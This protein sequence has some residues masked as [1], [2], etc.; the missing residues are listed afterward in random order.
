MYLLFSNNLRVNL[1]P[2]W[3]GTIFAHT[4]THTHTQCRGSYDYYILHSLHFILQESIALRSICKKDADA[5]C[6][7]CSTLKN[8]NAYG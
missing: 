3:F 8:R 7:L 4:H 6:H 1:I 5:M 2:D